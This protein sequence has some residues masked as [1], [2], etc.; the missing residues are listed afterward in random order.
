MHCISQTTAYVWREKAIFMYMYFLTLKII[1]DKFLKNG[2]MKWVKEV[3]KEWAKNLIRHFY[4]EDIQIANKHMKKMLIIL[5]HQENV[6]QNHS[7]I[8]LYNL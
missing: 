6:N 7:K 3:G 2:D 1:A 4:K 5:S 8:P